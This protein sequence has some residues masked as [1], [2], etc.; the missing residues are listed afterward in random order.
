MNY[1]HLDLYFLSLWGDNILKGD[2]SPSEK[3]NL[4]WRTMMAKRPIEE[5]YATGDAEY[6]RLE[7]IEFN[8]NKGLL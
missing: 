3:A 5:R 6:T 8:K 7:L 2:R 4:A 1:R